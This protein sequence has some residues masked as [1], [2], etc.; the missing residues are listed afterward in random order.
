MSNHYDRQLRHRQTCEGYVWAIRGMVANGASHKQ[1]LDSLDRLYACPAWGKLTGYNRYYIRGLID[2][3]MP[4]KWRNE[5]LTWIHVNPHNGKGIITYGATMPDG[6]HK[7]M[8]DEEWE[9]VHV[10]KSTLPDDVRPGQYFDM[11]NV[12][13]Y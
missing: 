5:L 7:R 13:R 10:Y 6:F 1:I 11:T 9:G 4:T 8:N 2:A 3:N 12:K